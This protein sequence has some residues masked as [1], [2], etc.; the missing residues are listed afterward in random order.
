MGLYFVTVCVQNRECLFGEIPGGKMILNDAGK[1]AHNEWLKTVELRPN[2]QLHNFIVMPNHFHAIVEIV[3]KFDDACRG[4]LHTPSN[5]TPINNTP[6]NNKIMDNEFDNGVCNQGVCNQG[7]C[8]TPLRSPSQTVG[9]IMRGYK[10]AVS[11][12]L[13]FS[14]WQRNYHEHIIR[15]QHEHGTI[16]EYIENN[17]INWEIDTFY[18]NDI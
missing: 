16:A 17:P 11:K 18:K 1:I 5:N 13:D 14:V 3:T 9:A 2:V 8:N 10:S 4:V 12:Q 7:V 6:I 15:D